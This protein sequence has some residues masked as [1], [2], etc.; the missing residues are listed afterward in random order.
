MS[1]SCLMLTCMPVKAGD[2]LMSYTGL[3]TRGMSAVTLMDRLQKGP[4]PGFVS[5]RLGP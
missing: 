5:V 4:E 2:V 3:S 1:C